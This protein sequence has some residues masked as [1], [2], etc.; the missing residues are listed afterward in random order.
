MKAATCCFEKDPPNSTKKK[1]K[2]LSLAQTTIFKGKV[3]ETSWESRH[4]KIPHSTGGLV[5]KKEVLNTCKIIFNV[6]IINSD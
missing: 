4:S 6:W 1:M 2:K 5:Y 3:V